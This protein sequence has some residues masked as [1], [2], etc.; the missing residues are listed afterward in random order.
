MKMFLSGWQASNREAEL[1]VIRKGGLRNRCFS[2]SMLTQLPGLPS[3][4]KAMMGSYEACV[5]NGVGIMLDSGVVSWRSHRA[6]LLREGNTKGL[7]KLCGED[8][9]CR[10]YVEFVKQRWQDWDFCVTVDLERDAPAIFERHWK[11]VGM[12]VDPVPVFHGDSTTDWIK[13]Y[14][15]RGSKLLA[16]GSW[17]TLRTETKA[18]RHYL[19]ACF[20]TAAKVGIRLHGLAM[21]APY[22]LLDY[23][24]HSVDSSAWTRFACY[25]GILSYNEQTCRLSMVRVTTWDNERAVLHHN[26]RLEAMIKELVESTGYDYGELQVSPA[27]RHAWNAREVQ[28]LA[29]AATKRHRSEGFD[30]LFSSI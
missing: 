16:I 18:Y 23:P 6:K 25:G 13:K 27:L 4:I 10:L 30:L 15:D 21:T 14:A 17:K 3:R 29:D 22:M 8:E 11:L 7:D 24:W 19:D 5:E 20:S 2:F 12:G 26:H 9:F 1:V 28:K